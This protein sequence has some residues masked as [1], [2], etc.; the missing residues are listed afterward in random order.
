MPSSC[1]PTL[2]SAAMW[3]YSF[4]EVLRSCI[5]VS[6][7]R[8]RKATGAALAE[9]STLLLSNAR[10][11]T[12]WGFHVRLSL[13]V[14]EKP[15]D[16]CS[17]PSAGLNWIKQRPRDS[18]HAV[19]KCSWGSGLTKLNHL[20]CFRHTMGTQRACRVIWIVLGNAPVTL[21][22]YWVNVLV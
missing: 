2:H 8:A 13:A 20:P 5:L 21:L 19:L 3:Q 10:S 1:P 4:T 12:F 11:C 7:Y 6:F 15:T 22:G 18:L 17:L 14:S 9:L 16:R